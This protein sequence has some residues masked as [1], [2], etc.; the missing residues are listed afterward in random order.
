ML[1]CE[2]PLESRWH[3]IQAF[4]RGV[5]DILVATDDPRLMKGS[6]G[7]VE[8]PPPKR[9]KKGEKKGAAEVSASDAEFGVSRGVDFCDVTAVVNMDLPSALS[10]YKH[11]I[12]RTARG[13][14]GGTAIS[15]VDENEGPDARL[16]EEM[17]REFGE[18]LHQ[19]H[20]DMSKLAA[21]RYR[22]EDGLRAVTRQ[23]VKEAR[24]KEIKQE[25]QPPYPP[26]TSPVPAPYPPALPP[27]ALPA[28]LPP[29]PTRPP[30][31]PSLAPLPNP[32]P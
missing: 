19:F 8:E 10:I 13:G 29:L 23:A 3:C 15:M 2:L 9:K 6:A 11:R 30:C 5:F 18:E 4:N 20:V 17:Q 12:G 28:P 32:P 14:K 27:P 25:Q 21:F 1:N 22:V 7:A 26:S 31:P 16:L 24:L